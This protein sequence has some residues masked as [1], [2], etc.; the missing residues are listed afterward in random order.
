[1]KH[2]EFTPF[3]QNAH[4]KEVER[5]PTED[6]TTPIVLIHGDSD[7]LVALESVLEHLT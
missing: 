6:I 2:G 1:M 3:H 4:N 7:S 5:Y